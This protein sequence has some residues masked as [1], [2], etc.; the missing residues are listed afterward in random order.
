LFG[1]LPQKIHLCIPIANKNGTAKKN[2]M[3][4]TSCLSDKPRRVLL[5]ILGS[6]MVMQYA[7][8]FQGECK[9]P[10]MM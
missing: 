5:G 10:K 1:L 7:S 2:L 6:A 9:Y 3:Q 8:M 4:K